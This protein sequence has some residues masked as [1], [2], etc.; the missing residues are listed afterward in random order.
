MDAMFPEHES[1]S[2]VLRTMQALID[3]A[4]GCGGAI[5]STAADFADCMSA[6]RQVWPESIDHVANSTASHSRRNGVEAA[7]GLPH[8]ERLGRFEIRKLLGHGGFGVVLLAFDSTLS[9]EVALKIPRPALLASGE[10][11][12]RFLSEAQSAALLDHP[13]IVT[14]YD[15]GEIGPVWYIAAGY[16]KGPSLAEWIRTAP[17]V[18]APRW[19]ASLVANLADAAQHAHS[20]GILHRDL[21][22]SNV[23]LEPS[24]ELGTHEFPFV[25]KLTDFG[26]AKR[27]ESTGDQTL[28]GVL[29]GTPRYM[30][31]EQAA[32]DYRE[33]GV[34]SDVY[35]LGVILYE[36]L[37]GQPPFVGKNDAETLLKIQGQAL[38]PA[39]LRNRRV[40]RDLETICLKCLEKSQA[41]RYQSARELADDLR[42]FLAGEAV[43]ARAISGGERFVRW[44]RRNRAVTALAAA[45]LVAMIAGTGVSTYYALAA[46]ARAREAQSALAQA[47]KAVDDSFTVLSEQRLLH[48]PG[49]QPLRRELLSTA[50]KYYEDFVRDHAGDQSLQSELAHACTR[51]ADIYTTIGEHG[52][53]ESL[54]RKAIEIRESL[55]RIDPTSNQRRHELA[56]GYNRL[57]MWQNWN[58]RTEETE[59]L[60]LKAI[61]IR[62]KLAQEDLK[63]A[64]YQSELAVSYSYLSELLNVVHG[65][66]KAEAPLR[67]ATEIRERLA[68]ESPAVASYQSDLAESYHALAIL[69]NNAGRRAESEQFFL[70]A[71]EI[72]ERLV[73]EAPTP[74]FERELA[75][76]RK[77]LA[78]LQRDTGRLREAAK[79][80]DQVLEVY[81]RLA[82]ENPTTIRNPRDLAACYSDVAKLQTVLGNDA[83]AETYFRKAVSLQERLIAI[84]PSVAGYHR[85]LA[86]YYNPHF[87]D[88]FPIFGMRFALHP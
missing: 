44:C 15:A 10:M 27:L 16:V 26:L 45:V 73:S 86:G 47:R 37:V 75:K 59:P 12:S 85:Q 17:S 76:S 65:W 42:R 1:E 18:L 48:E 9:R 68:L 70:K 19:S 72:S 81:E 74:D 55:A 62:E 82:R 32:G 87:P 14:V 25:P 29:I 39:S 43:H 38:S 40:P 64:G 77:H 58:R 54:Y 80:F 61:A 67:K 22:P 33:V 4:S 60:F 3:S 56:D 52:E 51:A 34:Q 13:G 6:L 66:A 50:L 35:S 28:P 21:K 78:V 41:S 20:R 7:S 88:E 24:D 49:M 30:A 79:S 36:L 63:N 46:S 69:H 5:D 83:D 57:A 84:D 23:M 31:P 2:E 53:A 8:G 11:R 71:I